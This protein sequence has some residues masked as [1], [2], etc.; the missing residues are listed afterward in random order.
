MAPI[1]L[2]QQEQ[3]AAM[4]EGSSELKYLLSKES[5]PDQYQAILYSVGVTTV[6]KFGSL[7]KDQDELRK[8]LKEDLGL[9]ADAGLKDRVQVANFICAFRNASTRTEE[10]AK[11][12]GEQEA[13]QQTKNLPQSEFLAMKSAFESKWWKL[14]D[15]DVPAR[16]FVEKRAEELESGEL[17]AECLT[18]VLNREQDDDDFLTPVWD[19]S[20]NLRVKKSASSVPEPENPEALRRRIGISFNAL[21][22]LGL[23]HTN[24]SFLQ[25]ITPQLAPRYCEYLLGEHVWG[26]I[27]KDPNGYTI[28]APSW[29]LVL[30]YDAAIR[31]KAYRL[32]ADGGGDFSTCLKTAWMDPTTKERSF[33]T[34]MAIAASTGYKSVELQYGLNKRA[35]QSAS[36][37]MGK[38]QKGNKGS[39]KGGGKGKGKGRGKKGKN[40][41]ACAQMTPDGQRICYSYNNA[42]VR[43]GKQDKCNF[44]HVCGLCFQKHPMYQ[45]QGNKGKA[46]ETSGAGTPSA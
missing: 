28:S 33:T 12:E 2:S 27:A 24:R 5:V 15:V 42:Q 43:C 9:D 3:D 37:S 36:G 31:K 10:I 44:L 26:L 1:V 18:S 22:F 17:R 8:L 41:A 14:E 39:V 16:T 46:P 23:R 25:N 21:M 40:T 20:G 45:C 13:R 34:P 29:S 4:L 38:F 35:A 32:M 19:Q 30:A 7:C 6:A 11:F